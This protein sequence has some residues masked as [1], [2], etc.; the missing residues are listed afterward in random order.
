M[1]RNIIILVWRET[2]KL[3]K[4][5]KIITQQPKA[6]ENQ[7]IAYIKSV[8]EHP[9]NSRKLFKAIRQAENVS[10][11]GAG[12]NFNR[13][14][15]KKSEQVLDEKNAKVTKWSRACK[16]YE[17]T[18]GVKILNSL[19]HELQL[20]YTEYAIR[21]KLIDLLTELKGLKFV[22]SLA[23]EFKKLDGDDKTICSIF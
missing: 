15:Y 22:K 14:L 4:R 3:V 8:T 18:S 10:Q 21:N 23:L 19:N 11:V 9:K 17:S 1:L 20:K 5:S 16:G 6:I 7:N 13:L 2:K 12:K